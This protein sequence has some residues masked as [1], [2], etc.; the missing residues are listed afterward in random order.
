MNKQIPMSFGHVKITDAITN[1][2]LVEN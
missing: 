2:I 1:E